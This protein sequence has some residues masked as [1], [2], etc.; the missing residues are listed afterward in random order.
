MRTGTSSI[1]ALRHHL[2]P[3]PPPPAPT[4][5]TASAT[6]SASATTAAGLTEGEEVPQRHEASQ[7]QVQEGPQEEGKERRYLQEAAL[8]RLGQTRIERKRGAAQA[9]GGAS[10]LR[11]LE[12]VGARPQAAVPYQSRKPRLTSAKNRRNASECRAS[13][14]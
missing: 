4:P 6:S 2:R 10:T 9:K 8:H 12:R 7:R 1:A 14:M 11:S 5:A 3:P 13:R